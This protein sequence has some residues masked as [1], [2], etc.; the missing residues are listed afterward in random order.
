[1][2]QLPTAL[3]LLLSD[4]VNQMSGHI[5]FYLQT[6]SNPYSAIPEPTAATQGDL[7]QGLPEE[8]SDATSSVMQ[9]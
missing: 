4:S 5:F 2:T 1:M 3:A 6:D 7:V 8:D 9:A